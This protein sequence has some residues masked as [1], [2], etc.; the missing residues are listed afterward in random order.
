MFVH[1]LGGGGYA[2]WQEMPQMMFEGIHGSP[3]DVAI[4][5]Y[6]S[7]LR[8]WKRGG[9]NL[10]APISRLKS[11]LQDL[12]DEYKYESIYIAAHSLGGI[13][14]ESAIQKLFHGLN[15]SPVTS[16]AAV[17]LF[18]SPRA[19]SGWAD[20]RAFRETRWLKRFSD[21]VTDAEEHFSSHIEGRASPAA[22]LSRF[23]LPH[24]ACVASDDLF[25]SRF[26]AE[27]GIP[28]SQ[29]LPLEG[30][31]TS[32]VK[33]NREDYP[34]V[35]WLHRIIKDVT[36]LRAYA[37]TRLAQAGRSSSTVIVS[38][39]RAGVHGTDWEEIYNEVR[40]ELSTDS[41]SVE[42]KQSHPDGPV[43][44]LIT[45]RPAEVVFQENSPAQAPILRVYAEYIGRKGG[46]FVGICTVGESWKSASDLIT[47][48]LPGDLERGFYVTG[49]TNDAGVYTVIT[50]WI[51]AAIQRNSLM[52]SGSRI[53]RVL[54]LA[55]DP[56]EIPERK[57]L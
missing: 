2:T 8:S 3:V 28:S 5:D 15:K 38:E 44:I 25:V 27:V 56:Y 37:R 14:A 12:S 39:L 21:H 53:D 6:R 10:S 17:I 7:G 40:K 11:A 32:V 30:S 47:Q 19:G 57:L 48:W 35:R 4:F 22:D 41:I 29:C 20:F 24:Y 42:D 54:D 52:Q 33:P 36:T 31:H 34:Q 51:R 46:L 43:D 18:A 45:V 26:S 13:I 16:L 49:A 55:P 1:G 23:F 50:K 9:A